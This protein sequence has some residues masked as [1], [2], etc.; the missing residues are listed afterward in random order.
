MTVVGITGHVT[1]P[2]RRGDKQQTIWAKHAGELVQNSLL[3]VYVLEH[4]KADDDVERIVAV[5]Q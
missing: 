2:I 4:F 5:L 3:I 1:I